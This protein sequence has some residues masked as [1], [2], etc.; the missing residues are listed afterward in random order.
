[1][2]TQSSTTSSSYILANVT[3]TATFTKYT[4]SGY[5]TDDYCTS[6]TPGQS[7]N[8]SIGG[9]KIGNLAT[10][11]TANSLSAVPNQ[12]GGG[13]TTAFLLIYGKFDTS[14]SGNAPAYAQNIPYIAIY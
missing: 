3:S 2:G 14:R 4:C 12:A 7:I 9:D 11:C 13:P 5:P 6:L 8:L 10:C 1:I